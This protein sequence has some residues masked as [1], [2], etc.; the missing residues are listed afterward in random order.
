MI[1]PRG[2]VVTWATNEL[3][4]EYSSTDAV[5]SRPGFTETETLASLPEILEV[6]RSE[7]S[8]SVPRVMNEM[9]LLIVVPKVLVAI[10]RA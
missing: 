6:F 8:G 2:T 10:S 7:T 3:S 1:N 4:I 9:T 5:D